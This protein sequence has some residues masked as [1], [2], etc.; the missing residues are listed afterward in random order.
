MKRP[1]KV[2][3]AVPITFVIICLFLIVMPCVE[4]PFEVGMGI[5]MTLSGIPAYYFGV[6]WH[7]KP[8][9]I[10]KIIGKKLLSKYVFNV[11]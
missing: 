2:N 4:A 10:K 8:V 1:I 5:L 6:C 3:I 11:Y 9:F 7:D